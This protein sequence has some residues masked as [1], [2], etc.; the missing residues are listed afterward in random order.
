MAEWAGGGESWVEVVLEEAG[1][2]DM[3]YDR[4]R[5][6]ITGMGLPCDPPR[7]AFLLRRAAEVGNHHAAAWDLAALVGEAKEKDEAKVKDEDGGAADEGE[8]RRSD[9]D[10]NGDGAGTSGPSSSGGSASEAP[11]I[12][13]RKLPTEGEY[14]FVRHH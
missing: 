12:R 13:K 3:I 7:G 14:L 2:W 4:A 9:G 11:A 8:A 1:E 6:M 10:D 5:R